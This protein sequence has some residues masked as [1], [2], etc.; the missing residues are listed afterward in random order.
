MAFVNN[1]SASR[2]LN[3]GIRAAK[4]LDE[5]DQIIPRERL[6]EMVDGSYEKTDPKKWWRPRV[7]SEKMLRMYFLSQR[8]NLSDVLTEESIYD[9]LSFQ[10]FMDI[11]ATSDQ[12]PDSTTLCGFRHFIEE[13]NLGKEILRIINELLEEAEV[14]MAW[15]KLVDATLIKAPSSTKNKDHKRDPEMSSTKKRGNRHFWA[16]IHIGTDEQWYIKEMQTTTAKTHD[17]QVY[18][19]LISHDDDHS[20][21]DAAYIWEDIHKAA[22]DKWVTHVAMKKRKRWQKRLSTADRLR[23]TLLAMPRKVVEFPFWVIKNLRGHRKTRYRWLGKLK[24]QWYSLSALC[25]I[26]RAR[27]KVIKRRFW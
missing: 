26:Y 24:N 12:I 10:C 2:F 16:K 20:L 3:K 21:W 4:F 27:Y 7:S 15:W 18:D 13:K 17:S 14:I 9:R 25:N 5:M 8:F 11:D 6:T 22:Q 19:D 23:N 1:R